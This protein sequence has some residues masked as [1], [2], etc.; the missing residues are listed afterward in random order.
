MTIMGAHVLPVD[1]TVSIS[2][3]ARCTPWMGH[4][5]RNRGHGKQPSVALILLT[6]GRVSTAA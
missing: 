4:G 6:D 1:Q 5:G 3:C 2:D